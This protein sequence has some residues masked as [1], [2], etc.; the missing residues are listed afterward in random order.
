MLLAAS[1][2]SERGQVAATT[3][4]SPVLA[5]PSVVE[6]APCPLAPPDLGLPEGAVCASSASGTF[7]EG[8]PLQKLSVYAFADEDGLPVEWHLHVTRD[9][10]AI[11]KPVNIGSLWSYPRVIGVAD[12]DDDGLDEAFVNVLTHTGHG[13]QTHELTIFGV[14]RGRIFRVLADGVPLLFP[15]GGV[16]TFGEGAECRD[17]DFDGKPEFLLLRVDYVFSP[18]QRLSERVYKWVHRHLE[19]VR[20][21]RGRM[22]KTGYLD[23]LLWRYYSLRCRDFVPPVPFSRG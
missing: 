16:S 2:C 14:E 6:G 23:P 17:V 3:T 13:G 18:V 21:N 4:P 11:D 12:A 8:K 15:V 9:G 19:F 1:A 5:S 22:A 7:E 20:R 10:D